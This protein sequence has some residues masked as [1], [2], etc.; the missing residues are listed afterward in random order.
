MFS[1]NNDNPRRYIKLQHLRVQS[2]LVL[3]IASTIFKYNMICGTWNCQHDRSS[4]WS[5]VSCFSRRYYKILSKP[6]LLSRSY[7]SSYMP[8]EAD[9]LLPM[10]SFARTILLITQKLLW[11]GQNDFFVQ[12][13]PLIYPHIS[14]DIFRTLY[15][16]K[17]N[18]N[19]VQT[20]HICTYKYIMHIFFIIYI[21][22]L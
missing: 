21:Y 14:A 3:P 7:L 8:I 22:T 12:F 20:F 18:R 4:E 2:S 11:F 16:C 5:T 13:H 1:A 17:C 10:R 19:N 6:F 15:M 9:L